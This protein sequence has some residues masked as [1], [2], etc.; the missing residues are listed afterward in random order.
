MPTFK[1][2]DSVGA[3]EDVSDVISCLTPHK[4]PF[5][6]SIGQETVKQKVYQW[7]EDELEPGADNA[8]LE[9]FDAAEEACTTTEMLQNTT[10]ILSRTIKLSGSLQATD[11]YGRANELARQLVK[12]GKTLRLD[13]E[14]AY[15]GVDQDMVLGSDAV[16]RRTKSVSKLIHTDNHI[17]AAGAPLDETMV[18]SAIRTAF[19]AGSDG[20]ETFMVKPTDAELVSEF[21]GTAD[22][23]RDVGINPSKVVVKVDIYTTALGTLRV[24]INREIKKD[25]AILYDPSMWRKTALKGRTWF[26]ETL[27]K[28]GDNTKVMLAGEYGLKHDNQRGAVLIKNLD[29]TSTNADDPDA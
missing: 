2:Y 15:V 25:F 26:R 21:A 1:T 13:L 7:Q 14:R 23:V 24:T 8:Q 20:A 17:D 12:K 28:T 3:K 4:V 6:S 9:G 11:H 18:R 5:T 27:A 19:N 16:A 22:R 29:V 10:Q